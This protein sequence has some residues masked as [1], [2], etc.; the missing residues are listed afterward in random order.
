MSKPRPHLRTL[1]EIERNCVPGLLEVLRREG[2]EGARHAL[3]DKTGW[4][5]DYGPCAW[6]S[7]ADDEQKRVGWET[8]GR[9]EEII[10]TVLH[11]AHQRQVEEATDALTEGP[12]GFYR[13][14]SE[15][16]EN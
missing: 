10:T 9:M 8:W 7:R 5:R 4:Y 6:R 1:E 3:W 15:R 14:G 16:R 11:E 12:E 13:S 2:I